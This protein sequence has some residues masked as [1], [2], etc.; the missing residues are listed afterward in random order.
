MFLQG[1]TLGGVL[2]IVSYRLSHIWAWEPSRRD[3]GVETVWN[4]LSLAM[5]RPTLTVL[6]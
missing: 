1:S 4:C 3:L 6:G 5:A 2:P